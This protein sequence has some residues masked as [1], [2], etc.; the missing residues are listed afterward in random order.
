MA[1]IATAIQVFREDVQGAV[2]E[3]STRSIEVTPSSSRLR[4]RSGPALSY[5]PTSMRT[6]IWGTPIREAMTE[7]QEV[8][9]G[10][11]L[12]RRAWTSGPSGY[13][14]PTP[15][16]RRGTPLIA[17]DRNSEGLNEFLEQPSWS[18][19][20]TRPGRGGPASGTA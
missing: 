5:A 20:S 10:A 2:D 8:V 14:P 7:I 13:S 12:V 17:R 6:R 1:S 19:G 18:A 11:D 9:A 4:C 16:P 3:A 15:T